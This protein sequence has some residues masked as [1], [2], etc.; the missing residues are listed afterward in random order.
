NLFVAGWGKTESANQNPIK[1]KLKVP[2]AERSQCSSKF[3]S[4]GITLKDSQIC[5]GGKKGKDSC[6]VVM[7][8]PGDSGGP[9][10][11]TTKNDSS[12]W[13]VEGLVSF[14]TKCGSE[15][16]P[17]VYTKV[18]EYIDWIYENVKE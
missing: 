7:L 8:L 17:G 13:Y 5:A 2:V 6:T 18:Y 4:A 9:L 11:R 12:Q 1:L 14:G 16:W 10:M 3:R 15:G